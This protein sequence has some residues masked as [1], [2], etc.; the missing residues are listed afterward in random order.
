MVAI[1]ANHMLPKAYAISAMWTLNSRKKIRRAHLIG[2]QSS[3]T[4]TGHQKP[5]D[6]ELSSV[7]VSYVESDSNGAQ[8]QNP[9]TLNEES[10]HSVA[11]AGIRSS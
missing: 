7:W 1:I 6:M 4:T 10:K 2:P 8:M 9:T 11:T 3:S 5:N